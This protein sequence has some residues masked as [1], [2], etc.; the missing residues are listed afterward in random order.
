MNL[1]IRYIWSKFFKKVK[2]KAIF[3]SKIHKTSKVEAG[4]EVYNTLFGKHSYCGYN[5]QIID[6]TIGSFTSI[7]NNVILGGGMHP[8]NWVST[9]PVFFEGIDSVK[10]KFS[11]FERPQSSRINIGND[12]WIG[13]NVIIKQGVTVGDGAVIGMGS[14]V[15]KDVEPYS[16]IAGNPARLIKKRFEQNII[17]KLL[18][19]SWWELDDSDLEKYS[20]NIKDPISFLK[21]FEK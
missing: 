3:N 10:R 13:T 2:S 1:D 20:H 19:C 9:S 11:T 14:I 21:N 15:T 4:S 17:D 6:C 16:I 12:V 8:Y 7:S 18:L 5:C